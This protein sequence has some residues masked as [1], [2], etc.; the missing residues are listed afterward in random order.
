MRYEQYI[1]LIPLLPLLGFAL[2]GLWGKSFF[3][4]YAG[5]FST[6][7]MAIVTILSL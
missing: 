7:L 3:R 2:L 5:I 6:L 4:Q 1:F